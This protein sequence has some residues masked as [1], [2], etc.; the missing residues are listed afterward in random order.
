MNLDLL[1]L[2][3]AGVIDVTLLVAFATY[4]VM[5]AR[6]SK[7]DRVIVQGTITEVF[8]GG[9]GVRVSYQHEGNTYSALQIN[10]GVNRLPIQP[11]VGASVQI[12]VNPFKSSNIT[13]TPR[14]VRDERGYIALLLA[15]FA[16]LLLSGFLLPILL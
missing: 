4:S 11:V 2:V 12:H 14:P 6:R 1:P 13:L 10:Q 3:I 8:K 15:L 9:S 5:L 16:A 7:V